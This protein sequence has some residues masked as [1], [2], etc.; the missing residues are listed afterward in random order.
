MSNDAGG[1]LESFTTSRASKR[2]GTDLAILV[3]VTPP[4]SASLA[5]NEKVS[6]KR[7]RSP[8]SLS[9]SLLGLAIVVTVL[10]T[11]T[12]RMIT[13]RITRATSLA[14]ALVINLDQDVDQW[15]TTITQLRSS[16]ALIQCPEGIARLRAHPASEIDLNGFVSAKK[17]TLSAYNDIV[18][19]DHVVV[20]VHLTLGALGCLESHVEAWRR[21]VSVGAPFLIF[22][23]DVTLSKEFDAGLILALAHLP[24]N[25]GLLYLANVIGEPILPSLSQ[26]N[27]RASLL[28][29]IT[30]EG[31]M[32][33]VSRLAG[34]TMANEW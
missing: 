20:G 18:E 16:T 24:P 2:R 34:R 27:V 30:S 5:N 23:D 32:N 26:Y 33:A 17:L 15:R 9:S 13:S 29:T 28:T 19:E 22:E 10:V 6:T 31:V 4:D 7:T 11:S 3:S 1:M 8:L 14:G 21:V 25:F 12:L